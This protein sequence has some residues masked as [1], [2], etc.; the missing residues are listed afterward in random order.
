MV[1]VAEADST[2][3][4]TA[5]SN[6]DPLRFSLVLFLGV[7]SIIYL[8]DFA[9]VIVGGA[10]VSGVTARRWGRE[11]ASETAGRG[12]RQSLNGIDF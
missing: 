9:G 2:G 7:A 11:G 6:A 8:Y 10:T 5:K 12:S 1:G 3:E 4:D